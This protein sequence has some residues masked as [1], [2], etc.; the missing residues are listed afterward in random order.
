MCFQ[1]C[2]VLPSPLCLRS[3]SSFPLHRPLNWTKFPQKSAHQQ[4]LQQRYFRERSTRWRSTSYGNKYGVE[5]QQ[6]FQLNSTSDSYLTK[7]IG[8]RQLRKQ[9]TVSKVLVFLWRRANDRNVRL[10]YPYWQYTDLFIFP[11]VSL[12]C[13]RSTLRSKSV[14]FFIRIILVF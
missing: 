13:L 8:T 7:F 10:Y 2:W 1:E 12:L 14:K 11:F 5:I 4:Q 6:I 9:A 3:F